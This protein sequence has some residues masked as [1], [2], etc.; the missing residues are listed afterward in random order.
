LSLDAD[1]IIVD[2]RDEFKAVEASMREEL[3]MMKTEFLFQLFEKTNEVK[4]LRD[5]LAE[6]RNTVAKLEEKV[7]DS[8]V[9]ERRDALV[10]SGPGLPPAIADE[11]C[12][13]LVCSIVKEKLKI[14]LLPTDI[15]TVHSLGKKPLH[16]QPDNR[17]IILKLC[18]RD[19][20]RDLLFACRQ[21]KPNIYINESLTP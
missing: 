2:I 19:I 4:C 5:E 7:E 10:I 6:L 17:N 8:D 13:T 14:N 1:K 18:R 3:N 12:S 21:F 11:F 15:S 9:Y 16:Q 20:K